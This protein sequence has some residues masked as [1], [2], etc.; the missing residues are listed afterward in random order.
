MTPQ[1]C[2]MVLPFIFNFVS[3]PSA[4]ALPPW[5]QERFKVIFVKVTRPFWT[6]LECP[7]ASNLTKNRPMHRQNA[8]G[9]VFLAIFVA[10]L[11]WLIFLTQYW[12]DF[13]RKIDV[14]FNVNIQSFF[15]F[16][17]PGDPHE[18]S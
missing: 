4:C 2:M 9:D 11:V 14:F 8:P 6:I 15:H 3:R 12:V 5:P 16:F 17:Q 18:T 13:Q 7:W 1:P 10:H